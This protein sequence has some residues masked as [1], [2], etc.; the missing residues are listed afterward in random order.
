MALYPITGIRS[1]KLKPSIGASGRVPILVG[2][3]PGTDALGSTALD[4][5]GSTVA[6]A[7]AGATTVAESERWTNSGAK[8]VSRRAKPAIIAIEPVASRIAGVRCPL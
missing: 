1:S 5:P 8:L 2:F 3:G 4:G 7:P 6:G